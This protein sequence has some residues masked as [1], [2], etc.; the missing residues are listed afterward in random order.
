MHISQTSLRNF[1]ENAL[2]QL[3]EK[4]I[5][6]GHHIDYK[7]D[8]SGDSK[9]KQYTEFLKDSTAFANANG[10]D[11]LI[12]VKE[13][14]DDLSIDDQIVGIENGNEIA[15]NL[16]RL[17]SSSIDPRIPGIQLIPVELADGK[18]VILIHIPP[19]LGKPHMVNYK[20]LRT[21]YIRHSESSFPMT[22]FDIKQTVLTSA[23]AEAQAK[24]YLRKM[25]IDAI[26]YFIKDNPAFLIQA[27]P[28]IPHEQPLD[29]LSEDVIETFQMNVSK[30]NINEINLIEYN[31]HKPTINGIQFIGNYTDP[32]LIIDFHSN[33]FIGLCLLN[34]ERQFR[35]TKGYML[36]STY[37]GLFNTFLQICEQLLN[38]SCFDSP[39]VVNAK[40]L[41]A[42]GTLLIYNDENRDF[43]DIEYK[44]SDIIWPDQI[45]QTGE[46]FLP[47]ADIWL[48]Q[49]FHAFGINKP[50]GM[51]LL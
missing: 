17:A 42:D 3:L 48:E 26:Y 9:E 40:Y 20:K 14:K 30:S 51:Q 18:F 7:V 13:P 10:G 12:G 11:I 34:G 27:M 44:K 37:I 36:H 39:Y 47:I 15:K 35:K 8:L 25:E 23:T 28:I 43:Y 50:N 31:R 6:E 2:K 19:S 22:T 21:F 4:R 33:G 32:V 45:R 16:E 46:P 24:E 41:N 49:M 1:D 5:P 38:S 29:V